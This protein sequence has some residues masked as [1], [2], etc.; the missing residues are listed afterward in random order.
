MGVCHFLVGVR[1]FGSKVV[2]QKKREMYP[3]VPEW[4]KVKVQDPFDYKLRPKEE[5]ADEF[6]YFP[7]E[8]V[9]RSQYKRYTAGDMRENNPNNR[10]NRERVAKLR[11]DLRQLGLAPLQRQRFQYLLG[12][13]FDLT[14]PHLAKVVISQYNTFQENFIRANETLREIYWEAK[15]APDTNTTI[16]QNPYRREFLLKKFFGKTA[17]ERRTKRRELKLLAVQHKEDVDNKLMAEELDLTEQTKVKTTKR[18]D[19]AS[20]RAKLGFKD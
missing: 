2:H 1:S 15:R 5:I 18:R 20:R 12:P 6:K 8:F 9:I 7:S 17:E 14:K 4:Q 11:V 13:R 16:I 19:Y 3:C 10:D